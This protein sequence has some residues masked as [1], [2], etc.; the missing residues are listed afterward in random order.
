MQ[1]RALTHLGNILS[2]GDIVMG[3]DMSS[4]VY[5]DA[6]TKGERPLCDLKLLVS[7]ALR[8]TCVCGIK[9]LV[10]A[11]CSLKLLVEAAVYNDANTKGVR[12]AQR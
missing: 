6:D 8:A 7:A 10:Y 4:A 2:A 12:P 11:V 5:N 1:F 3:Y 9:L